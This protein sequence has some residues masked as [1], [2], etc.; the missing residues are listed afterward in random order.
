VRTRLLIILLLLG[1]MASAD[2]I[3][4]K[5]GRAIHA[6]SV[7]PLGEKIQYT[8]GES[9]F[10]IP[11]DLVARIDTSGPANV[12]SAPAPPEPAAAEEPGITAP[13]DLES[14]FIRDGAIDA[15]SLS[16]IERA[17]P[18]ET[19]AAADWLAANLSREHGDLDHA[20]T[21]I[22]RALAA[23]PQDAGLLSA[24]ASLLERMDRFREAATAATQATHIA[25]N[26]AY[27]FALLGYAQQ[28][29]GESAAAVTSLQRSLALRPDGSIQR[30][31]AAAEHD[32]TA[33]ATLEASPH[34]LLQSSGGAVSPEL[35]RQVLA[36]LES[37]YGEISAALAYAPDGP[38]PVI[39]YMDRGYFESGDVP[40]W[41]SAY[42]DGK[43]RVSVVGVTS[44][45]PG[46]AR[47]L[48][49]ELAHSFVAGLT[50]HRCPTWLN[51]GV[52]EWLEPRSLSGDSRKLASLYA[53][54]RQLPLNQLEGDFL[55]FSGPEAML[56]Y[57]ESLAAVDYLSG[58]YG[59]G[60]VAVL[61][62]RIGEGASPEAALRS[63]SGL[64]YAGFEGALGRSLN[65]PASP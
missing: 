26:S 10:S 36:T 31:L 53:A 22:E 48:K 56:A 27:A 46:L 9:T 28:Q 49:H 24:K 12:T 25:P 54:H 45:S 57:D 59:A 2:V 16:T 32:A 63:V 62:R 65:S 13:A 39:L 11:K 50:N 18:P 42:N 35:R 34:F 30:L 19:A 15:D 8:I 43:L 60:A 37:E 41:A 52:A 5:N 47:T 6:D 7:T 64:G 17:G 58:A 29:M 51:E 21:Y 14:K 1:G 23:L 3:V 38:I 44:V 61:L 20:L 4:L 40:S 33:S 55:E